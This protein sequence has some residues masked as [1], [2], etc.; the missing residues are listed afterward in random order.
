[1]KSN[2]VTIKEVARHANVSIT[3]VSMVLSDNGKISAK[4]TEKVNQSIKELGY[5]RNRSAANL[6]SKSN[7]VVG[8][9]VNDISDSYYSQIISGVINEIENHGCMIYLAECG[10]RLQDFKERIRAMSRQGVGGIVVC[11]NDHSSHSHERLLVQTEIPAVYVSSH[12][13]ESNID[14][15]FPDNRYGAKIAAEYLVKQGHK[16]MA[17]LGGTPGS[18]S[19]AERISGLGSTL[20]KHGLSLKPDWIMPGSTDSISRQVQELLSAY[21]QLTALICDNA[22]TTLSAIYGAYTTGRQV[23]NE[24]YIEKQIS[25]VGFNCFEKSDVPISTVNVDAKEMGTLAANYL[26]EKIN[27]ASHEPFTLLMQPKLSKA[28]PKGKMA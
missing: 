28:N 14:S 15:V 24:Q 27:S 10:S 12:S 19:R 20:K 4:T 6:R 8:L 1:M 2:K 21:P 17:Y 18:K 3:T 11:S 16:S 7:D 22:S 25:V 26:I 13:I 5:I 23:G 9:I